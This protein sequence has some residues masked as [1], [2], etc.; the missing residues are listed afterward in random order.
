MDR[1]SRRGVLLVSPAQCDA[2]TPRL[3]VHALAI[4]HFVA[5]GAYCVIDLHPQAT[6]AAAY[7]GALGGGR[8]IR[9]DLGGVTTIAPV[10]Y[11]RSSGTGGVP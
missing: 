11:C 6:T 10:S 5:G 1:A 2:N 4:D 3:A 9:S 7:R 8:S